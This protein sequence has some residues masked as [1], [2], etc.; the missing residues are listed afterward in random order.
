MK[1]E[2]VVN[3]ASAQDYQTTQLPK[4]DRVVNEH[5]ITCTACTFDNDKMLNY[6]EVCGT[7]L[8]K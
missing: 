4:D 8:P 5:V 1:P 7:I 6:C 3:E 2:I